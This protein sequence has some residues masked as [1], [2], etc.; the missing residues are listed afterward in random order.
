[1][2]VEGE[3]GGAASEV[4]TKLGFREFVIRLNHRKVLTGILAVAGVP[5]EKHESALIALDKLDKIGRD[6]VA[7][8]FAVRGINEVPGRRLLEFF[9]D[10]ASLD[11]AAEVSMGENPAQKTVAL[12]KAV[13]GRLVEFVGD[14]EMGS[15]GIDELRSIMHVSESVGIANHLRIA[16]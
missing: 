11:H 8:E 16:P 2:V 1:M 10:L 9:V 5:L 3:I 13:L 7:K 12:N 4:L 14:N 6:G 15:R